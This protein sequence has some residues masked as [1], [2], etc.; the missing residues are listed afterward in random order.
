MS[1]TTSTGVFPRMWRG[2]DDPGLPVGAWIA[3]AVSVGNATG[4]INQCEF[5]FKAEDT[6]VTG[7]FYSL[8]QADAFL[9]AETLQAGFLT[10]DNFEQLGPFII[11]TRQWRFEFQTNA[12]GVAAIH[13]N[14]G[15]P[16]LPLFL[17]QTPRIASFDAA[18]RIGATNVNI[19]VLSAV[20]QGFIWE[21]RSIMAEGGLRRPTD[22]VY[23]R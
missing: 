21:P 16:E 23:G 1:V 15:F 20:V 10:L 18:M 13:F 9:T 17:G 4:G 12:N 8:E 5:L 3:H 14:E 6:P 19:V 11:A 7:R 22:S 2:Y